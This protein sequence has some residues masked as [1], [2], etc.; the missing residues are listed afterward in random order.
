M[1]TE[2]YTKKM[3]KTM[4]MLLFF[5]WALGN[6]DRYL[7]NYAVVYIGDDLALTA[8]QTGL[9]LSSFFLGYAFMQMPGGLLADKFGAK[10]VLLM[11]VIV[12]SIFTGLTAVAWSL[13]A[14]VVVRFLFGIGEGGFQPAASKIIATVFPENERSKAM[15]VMLASGAIMA[16]L[17]PILSAFLLTT[18]GWRPIFV[19]CGILGA[20]IAI[21]YWKYIKLPSEEPVQTEEQKVQNKGILKQLLS[22]PFMWSLIVSYFT[23]YAVNWGLNSWLPKYL[24]DVR[25]LDLMSIGYLQM[26]PGVLMLGCMFAFGIIIDKLTLKQNKL[27]GAICALFVGIFLFLMFNTTSIAMFIVYQCL[28]SAV[29]TY[30]VL[31][32]PS[33]V[34]KC[35]PQEVSGTAMGMANTGGQLAGFVTPTLMGFMVDALDGSYNGAFWLLIGF[36]IVCIAAIY[37]IKVKEQ[38]SNKTED[39]EG[40]ITGV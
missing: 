11:A 7:I 1:Q 19:V 24:T 40:V 28:V 18:V 5:G 30:I 4:L 13:A 29:M 37:S 25:N 21:L 31:L 32:L 14:M 10:K 38:P 36:A 27:V 22:M 35:I 33:F 16:M 8:T 20:V 23:I 17:V 6:L 26:I 15:S 9:I 12:W 34:L 3:R 39:Q 2:L